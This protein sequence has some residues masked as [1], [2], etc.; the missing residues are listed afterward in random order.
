MGRLRIIF[1]CAFLPGYLTSC[2]ENVNPP[3]VEDQEFAVDENSAAGTIVGVVIAYDEDEGQSVSF[4]IV[5][6]NEEGIFEID[7]IGGHLSVADPVKLDYEV[8]PQVILSVLVSDDHP[9]DPMES[10]VTITVKLNDLNEFPPVIDDQEFQ[11]NENPSMGDQIGIIVATDP[12]THQGLSFRLLS[13]NEQELVALNSESGELTVN[14]PSAFDFEV[15]PRFVFSV[16][17]RDI[18]LDSK[19]DTATVTATVLDLPE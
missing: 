7:P 8:H 18:H 14:D 4:G 17:V 10:L 5:G 15:N 6:G 13:G 19:T 16:L 11:I 1:L 9:K 2:S 12:E 3:Q